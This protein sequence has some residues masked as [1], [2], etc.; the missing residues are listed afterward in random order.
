M[1]Q[2]QYLQVVSYIG[3]VVIGFNSLNPH[4]ASKHHFTY[5]KNDF[6]SYT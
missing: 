2:N 3:V 4:D 6:I 5:P 1:Y